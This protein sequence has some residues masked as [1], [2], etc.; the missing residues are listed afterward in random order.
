VIE[1]YAY[2]VDPAPPGCGADMVRVLPTTARLSVAGKGEIELHVGG[3]GCVPGLDFDLTPPV[4][5]GASNRTIRAPKG[6]RRVRV[7]YSVTAQDNVDGAIA[8]SC[9]PKRGARS[10]S[11]VR[12]SVCSAI[13]TSGNERLSP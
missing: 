8:A 6:R 2:E 1:S 4:L 10:G 13:D 9:R 5:A 7:V 3:T 12:P 11:V